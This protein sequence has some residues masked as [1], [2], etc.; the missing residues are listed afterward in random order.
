MP[1]RLAPR[2]WGGRHCEICKWWANPIV[3]DCK[4]NY[5]LHKWALKITCVLEAG[6]VP[7]LNALLKFIVQGNPVQ[8]INKVRNI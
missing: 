4:S 1:T 7:F 6:D 5:L 3:S 2:V 8:F